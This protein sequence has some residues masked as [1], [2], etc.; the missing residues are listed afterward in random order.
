MACFLMYLFHLKKIGTENDYQIGQFSN[1]IAT[2]FLI[3]FKLRT[4]TKTV[5]TTMSY[6]IFAHIEKRELRNDSDD[7]V[8]TGL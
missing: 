3:T 4:G 2:N 1:P 8:F 6:I 5:K 7:A